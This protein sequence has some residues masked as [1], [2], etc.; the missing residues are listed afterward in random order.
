MSLRSASA[1]EPNGGRP[2]P[3]SGLLLDRGGA[4][5]WLLPHRAPGGSA[6]RAWGSPRFGLG[7]A[8]RSRLTTEQ[9]AGR[10]RPPSTMANALPR[11]DSVVHSTGPAD[12]AREGVPSSFISFNSATNRS[13][14][15]RPP[16]PRRSDDPRTF[17]QTSGALRRDG[18][19]SRNR[20]SEG[21]RPFS[22]LRLRGEAPFTEPCALAQRRTNSTPRRTR[23]LPTPLDCELTKTMRAHEGGGLL[24]PA[25]TLVVDLANSDVEGQRVGLLGVVR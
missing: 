1:N 9:F 5:R 3:I 7:S 19:C 22:L 24:A 14:L 2:P 23:R 8:A 15:H 6:L 17:Y 16:A 21:V 13:H 10:C 20:S 18:S 25:L 12:S 11:A 4:L